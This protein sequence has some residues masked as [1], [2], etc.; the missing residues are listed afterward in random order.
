[1]NSSKKNEKTDCS[2]N[3]NTKMDITQHGTPART[4][5][6][7]HGPLIHNTELQ[8]H[9]TERAFPTRITTC[10]Q[11]HG[12]PHNDLGKQRLF[13]R[14]G[15]RKMMGGWQAHV[16]A[17]NCGA[18]LLFFFVRLGLGPGP[19]ARALGPGPGPWPCSRVPSPGPGPGSRARALVPG[20]W[21]GPWSRVPG[22]GPTPSILTS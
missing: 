4:F 10:F 9:N 7:Q 13:S 12:V 3:D 17:Q 1:M 8:T 21:P 5:A 20:P 22:P 18:H 19:W 6:T 11:K 16:F 15:S 2:R 14:T